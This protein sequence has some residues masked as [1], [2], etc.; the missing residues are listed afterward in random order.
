M[1]HNITR[2]KYCTVGNFNHPCMMIDELIPA[3]I[4]VLRTSTVEGND[5]FSLSSLL[6]NLESV[7]YSSTRFGDVRLLYSTKVFV[8]L[9]YRDVNTV[10]VQYSTSIFLGG[11]K[12]RE[13]ERVL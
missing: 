12:R 9:V 6:W 8:I 3:C 1:R 13:S 4:P 2:D 7:Y 11:V 10:L 5:P